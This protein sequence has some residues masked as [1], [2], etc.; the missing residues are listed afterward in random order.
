M[1]NDTVSKAPA[2][3][4]PPAR[5]KGTRRA[6]RSRMASAVDWLAVNSPTLGPIGALLILF[7]IFSIA[8]G[9][10]FLT[11]TN[12]TN[13]L[14]QSSVIAVMATG[15]TFVLLLGEIDLAFPAIAVLAGISASVFYAGT[16]VPMWFLGTVHW[17]PH[18][19]VFAIAVAAVIS[20]LVGALAGGMTAKLGVPSFIATLGLLLLCDGWSFYWSQGNVAYGY[21][22]LLDT[23]GSSKIGPIPVIAVVAGAVMLFAH[24]AL[25][26]TR[27]GR[28]IYMT[29]SNRRAAE[30]AGINTGRVIVAVFIVSGMLAGF[31]GLLAVGRLGSAQ[32][33]ISSDYLL[34]VIAATVVGGVSLFGGAGNIRATLVGVL[35]FGVLDNGLDQTSININLKPFMRGLILLFAIV[36]NVVGLRLAS[37]RRIGDQAE[38]DEDAVVQAAVPAAAVQEG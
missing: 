6:S 1:S 13:V 8:A 30:L 28:Y 20:L 22:S 12:I 37:R 18:S 9:S 38:L 36:I 7:V 29:G 23:L 27:F 2:L 34:P 4:G 17:A 32:P 5:A 3:N 21:P 19:A 35:I 25:A 33:G 10:S 15:F 14:A 16:G 11:G 26:H 24:I 31:A